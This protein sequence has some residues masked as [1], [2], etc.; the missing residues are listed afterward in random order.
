MTGIILDTC[1]VSEPKR[2]DPE[3]A[4]KLWLESVDLDRLFLTSTVVGEISEGIH[5]MPEGRRRSV[6]LIWLDNLVNLH[7][8]GRIL[9]FDCDAALLYGKVAAEAYA[10]GRPPSVGDAQIAAIAVRFGMAVATR[11]TRDFEPFG[12]P[13]INPWQPAL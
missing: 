13:L 12:V 5:R 10:S 1:V 4:V 11:N 6:L 8:A 3:P 2:P 7:F 9:P